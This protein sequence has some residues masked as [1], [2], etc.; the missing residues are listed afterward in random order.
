MQDLLKQDPR[1]PLKITIRPIRQQ[2]HKEWKALWKDYNAFYGREGASALPEDVIQATWNRLMSEAG[3]VH[4]LVAESERRLVG[5]AHIIFHPNT[6]HIEDTC[7]LQDLFT[8]T[9]CRGRGVARQL[10]GAVYEI[11]RSRGV[12]SVYWHTH[13]SN[14]AARLLYDKLATNTGFL[15]Y[16]A[17]A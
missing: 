10:V 11:C 13:A 8:E 7:Y 6:I 15:V 1:M 16:R 4:G 5:F 14:T 3:P 9:E 12:S 17:K 2:D